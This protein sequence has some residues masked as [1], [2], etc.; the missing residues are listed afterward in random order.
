MPRS[1]KVRRPGPKRERKFEDF[2][3]PPSEVLPPPPPVQMTCTAPVQSSATERELLLLTGTQAAASMPI[4]TPLLPPASPQ[5]PAAFDATVPLSM[6]SP[7]PSPLPLPNALLPSTAMRAPTS[8]PGSSY[9]TTIFCTAPQPQVRIP[10]LASQL[11]AV[12]PMPIPSATSLQPPPRPPLPPREYLQPT[13]LKVADHP[14]QVGGSY[15]TAVT[16]TTSMRVP[17]ALRAL[18]SRA[19]SGEWRERGKRLLYPLLNRLRSSST[20][21]SPSQAQLPQRQVS[22]AHAITAPSSVGT[23]EQTRPP[24]S[25]SS[26][27]QPRRDEQRDL[28]DSYPSSAHNR[29]SVSRTSMMTLQHDPGQPT[30]STG[31]AASYSRREDASLLAGRHGPFQTVTFHFGLLAAFLLPFHTL[32]LQI[33]QH[34]VD[35]WCARPKNMR[36]ISLELWKRQMIPRTADGRYSKCRMYAELNSTDVATVPCTSW[37][38]EPSTYGLSLVQEFDLVCERAWYMPLSCSAFG[39]GAIGALLVSGPLADRLGR[40]PVMQ[41]SAVA[42][43]AAGVVILFPAILNSF[44]T[45]RF[46]LGA[47]TNTL[48]NTS[49]VLVVEVLAPE[50]R[51]LYSM[52]VMMGKVFGAI[53]AASLMWLQFSWYVL[54]LISMLPCFMMLVFFAHLVESPR[55][56]LAR[57]HIEEAEAVILHAATLNGENLF[58]VRQQWAR[59]RRNLERG[60]SDGATNAGCCEGMRLRGDWWNSV[61]L[62]YYWTVT[63]FAWQTT[64]LKIHYLDF[65]PATLLLLSSLLSFPT[66]LVAIVS[67]ARLGRRTSQAGALFFGAAACLMATALSEDD[68]VLTAALLLTAI[69]SVDASQAIGTLYTAEVYPTVVRCSGLALCTCFSTVASIATPLAVYLGLLPVSSASLSVVALLCVTAAIFALHLPV[70]KECSTLPDQLSDEP[71][72]ISP[73]EAMPAL[74]D[75]ITNTASHGRRLRDKSVSLDKR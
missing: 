66:E 51:T 48:F 67:A 61:I 56:L 25:L 54:Q 60:C 75:T 34:E 64:S 7:L 8:P 18:S 3:T 6:Q 73:P 11:A 65:Y 55:W 46:L 69:V 53:I 49:F 10:S 30:P 35:H 36:N 32:P 40:K 15:P 14:P 13:N 21:S 37:E 16:G 12:Y 23:D 9:S 50:R 2:R 70:S 4:Q 43:Q 39:M 58:E 42:L 74:P 27:Q 5:A 63:A 22:V 17:T 45:M 47:A 1:S 31:R 57:T 20:G 62:Y 68:V 38:Y 24:E 41:F 29:R 26:P 72:E 44:L 52:I 19:I 59:A 28:Q 33:A 71:F